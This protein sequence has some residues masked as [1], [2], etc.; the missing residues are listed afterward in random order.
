MSID[1]TATCVEL[2]GATPD[3]Q[4]D[5]VSLT[6]VVGHPSRFDNRQLLYER[7]STEGYTFPIYLPPLAD[8]I[9]TRN[10][11]LVRYRSIPSIY[12]LYDID[13]DPNELRN[14]ADHP[15]YV[16]DRSALELAL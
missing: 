4:L 16:E 11:K 5:G 7:G 6:Q 13:A 8:G 3:L 2:A 15:D 12:E 14:L 1:L 9:F 10:R